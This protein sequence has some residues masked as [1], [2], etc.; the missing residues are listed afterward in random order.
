MNP[1]RH[2]HRASPTRLARAAVIL[3][4]VTLAGGLAAAPAQ[5][6]AYRYWGYFHLT[7]GAWAFAQTG[8]AQAIPAD[9]AVEGWRFAVADESSMRTP[10]VTPTFQALCAGTAIKTGDKRVGLV[11]DFGRPADAV[12]ADTAK[13]PAPQ[14]TCV[15]VPAKA[16]G[17][18]VLVAGGATLRLA[19]S[20][21]CGIDGWPATG[22]G[23]AVAPVPAAAAVADTAIVIAAPANA[24]AAARSTPA[25]ASSNS[26]GS[27]ILGGAG[28]VVLVALLGFA[29]W[30]R[31]RDA[32]DS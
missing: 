5:A 17:S 3:I 24:M 32:T 4:M 18:D 22:C 2:V 1:T 19:K 7:K 31:G 14:A 12:N 15:S 16:T 26:S 28:V 25:A 20:L 13:P 9:G 29:A 21:T 8:P 23:E 11:I 27:L 10:R 30:R 6:A